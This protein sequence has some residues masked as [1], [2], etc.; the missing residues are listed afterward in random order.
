MDVGGIPRDEFSIKPDFFNFLYFRH[1]NGGPDRPFCCYSR[2]L[3]GPPMA[4]KPPRSHW[5][6]QVLRLFLFSIYLKS[7]ARFLPNGFSTI[8]FSVIIPVTSSLGVTS[9]AG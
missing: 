4:P 6:S 9:K 8:S 2:L 3:L 7:C 5:H 1:S